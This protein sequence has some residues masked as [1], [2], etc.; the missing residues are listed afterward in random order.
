MIYSWKL[1]VR[2]R[3]R[4]RGFA[5]SEANNETPSCVIF[6]HLQSSE[7]IKKNQSLWFQSLIKFTIQNVESAVAI[8][9]DSFQYYTRALLYHHLLSDRYYTYYNEFNM[10]SKDFFF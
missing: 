2:F 9:I 3:R 5:I 7:L 6:V 4:I 1:S 10:N 8:D